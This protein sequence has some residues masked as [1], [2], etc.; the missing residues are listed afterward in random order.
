M[1]SAGP[2][3]SEAGRPAAAVVIDPRCNEFSRSFYYLLMHSPRVN[4]A[5]DVS[6]IREY[7][8]SK[9]LSNSRVETQL[10]WCLTFGPYELPYCSHFA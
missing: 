1:K 7:A 5:A 10:V 2:L 3:P 4:H 8:G 6:K 9:I